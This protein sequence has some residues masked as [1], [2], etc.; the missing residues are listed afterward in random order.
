[1]ATGSTNS[2]YYNDLAPKIRSNRTQLIVQQKCYTSEMASFPALRITTHVETPSTALPRLEALD[3]YCVRRRLS[4]EKPPIGGYSRSST[5]CRVPTCDKVPRRKGLCFKH[6]G[7]TLCKI[8]GCTSCAHTRQLC[9]KHGGGQRCKVE[10]CTQAAQ[11][12][13]RCCKHGGRRL[14]SFKDCQHLVKANK[15]CRKHL[16]NSVKEK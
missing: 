14:C 13:Q 11:L 9:I 15:L 16:K 12:H 5:K 8:I 4:M 1:M 2:L 10:N 6:G 7:K 3:R